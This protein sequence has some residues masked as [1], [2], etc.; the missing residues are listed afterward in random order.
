MNGNDRV[1]Y[2]QDILDQLDGLEYYIN[3]YSSTG[4]TY[5][6]LCDRYNVQIG[7]NTYPCIMFNDEVNIT[8]GLEELI[9][10]DTPE[11]SETDYT[12]A[13]KTDRRINQTTLIVDKHEQ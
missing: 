2:L 12:K 1:D 9:H 11:D 7:E 8:Q 13:D 6:D 3:D 10:T 4:I 5:F